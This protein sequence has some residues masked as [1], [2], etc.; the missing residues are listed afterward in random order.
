[1]TIADKLK[2]QIE[3]GEVVFLQTQ[4]LSIL[5]QEF[6][7][8]GKK[9]S[10]ENFSQ[11]QHFWDEPDIYAIRANLNTIRLD[12]KSDS[13]YKSNYIFQ[14]YR[15]S[16]EI[17]SLI[18]EN[19]SIQ[20][21]LGQ[22]F[23]LEST[24]LFQQVNKI[25]NNTL[26]LG[27]IFANRLLK[28]VEP[29]NFNN[30]ILFEIIS[31]RQKSIFEGI[32]QQISSKIY[33]TILLSL[34]NYYGFEKTLGLLESCWNFVTVYYHPPIVK[35]F[36]E[37]II[38][39]AE[40]VQD[41]WKSENFYTQHSRLLIKQIFTL[42]ESNIYL[43]SGF[44]NCTIHTIN[45]CNICKIL[46]AGDYLTKTIDYFYPFHLNCNCIFLPKPK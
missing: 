21:F 41:E 23:N 17:K 31:K 38:I 35:H 3:F 2:L 37:K 45:D 14:K 43:Q 12:E 44:D 19:P 39:L 6:I 25:L 29:V 42:A 8:N 27:S 10:I 46:S 16:T 30:Q 36:G 22:L 1:M 32:M 26:Q 18:S 9:L 13:V 28:N 20:N 5:F 34:R 11:H 24:E 4:L 7:D 33:Y 40:A 15:L